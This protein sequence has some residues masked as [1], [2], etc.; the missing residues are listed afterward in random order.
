MHMV[1]LTAQAVSIVAV[2]KLDSQSLSM[3]C[4]TL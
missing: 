1:T 4:V 3:F 2:L